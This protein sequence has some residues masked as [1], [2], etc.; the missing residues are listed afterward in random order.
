MKRSFLSISKAIA[1]CA[2]NSF[3]ELYPVAPQYMR[4]LAEDIFD[5]ALDADPDVDF[6]DIL[7]PCLNG[8]VN[9]INLLLQ[10][11]G[12]RVKSFDFVDSITAEA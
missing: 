1:I 10:G 6:D 7:Q 11:S 8:D 12:R 9:R 4:Q 2:G 3:E 5:F